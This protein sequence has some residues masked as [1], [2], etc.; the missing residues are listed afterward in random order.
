MWTQL[1]DDKT[2]RSLVLDVQ[3]LKQ[4]VKKLEGEN[5]MVDMI[6]AYLRSNREE[7]IDGINKK[8]NLPLI[9]EAKEEKIFA[10][11]FDGMMEVLE[12]VLNKKK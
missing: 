1:I 9:S 2:F 5:K 3:L 4:K 7:I 12:G 6:M 10:S 8:V 11:L